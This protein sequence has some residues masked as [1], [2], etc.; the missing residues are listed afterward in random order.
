MPTE[1]TKHKTI[2]DAI[3][4][5]DIISELVE[6]GHDHFKYELDLEVVVYGRNYNGKKVGPYVRLYEFAPGEEIIRQGD[7][8][9]S[10]FYITVDGVCDAY[11]NDE[12]G[13]AKKVGEIPAG[14]SFGEMAILAGVPR[15]AT[16]KASTGTPAT[17]LEVTRPALRLLRKLPK[18]GQN[19][20]VSYRKHG[21]LSL[22]HI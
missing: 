12:N 15:N 4:K 17:V 22:I 14:I 1:I 9:S 21:L 20:D 7:W 13:T 19:L 10:T 16:V 18:F 2:L 3:G 11:V 8:G 6:Q 5:V